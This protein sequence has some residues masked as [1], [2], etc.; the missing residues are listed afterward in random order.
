MNDQEIQDTRSQSWKLFDRIAPRYDFLNRIISLGQDRGWR[1]QLCD[2]VPARPHLKLLDVATGTAD[3]AILLCRECP[4]IDSAIGVDLS[5]SMLEIGARKVRDAKLTSRLT[6]QIGDAQQLPFTDAS[7]DVLTV[8]FGVRNFPDL[9]RALSEFRRVLKP[10]GSLLIL[11]S[12]MP[13]SLGLK[14]VHGFYLNR[15]LPILGLVFA[16]DGAAYR[17]LGKTIQSFPYGTAFCERLAGHGFSPVSVTPLMAGAVC[18]YE[19]IRR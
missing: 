14:K 7:F 9:D 16:R 10:C 5:Q 4:N 13:A 15:I 12:A 11:E 1:R 2:R 19:G 18:V 6:L 3:V 17:Y 8:S